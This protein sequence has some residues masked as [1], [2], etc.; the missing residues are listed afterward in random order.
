LKNKDY[1]TTAVRTIA[2]SQKQYT[3]IIGF[4]SLAPAPFRGIVCSPAF[5]R[6]SPWRGLLACPIGCAKPFARHSSRRWLLTPRRSRL[7]DRLGGNA[8]AA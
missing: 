6:A 5:C 3:E 1:L 4:F 2:P 7:V 8:A